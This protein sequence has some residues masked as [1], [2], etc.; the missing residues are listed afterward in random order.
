MHSAAEAAGNA[1]LAISLGSTLSV[2]PAAT[3]PLLAAQRGAPYIIINQGDT[4]HDS[5]PTVTLRLEGD[6]TEIFSPA[7]ELA[8]ENALNL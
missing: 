7:V 4:D 8:L 3:F 2:Y 6:V 1:D 5:Y